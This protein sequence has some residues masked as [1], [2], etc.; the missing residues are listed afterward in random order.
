[1]TQCKY[2]STPGLYPH[3]NVTT[4]QLDE[5]EQELQQ[6]KRLLA[7]VTDRMAIRVD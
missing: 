7:K 4:E 5:L 6:I 3:N 1:M 2:D